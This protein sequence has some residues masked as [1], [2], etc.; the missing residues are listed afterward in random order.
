MARCKQ[1]A[2]VSY[3]DSVEDYKVSDWLKSEKQK[4]KKTHETGSTEEFFEMY[5]RR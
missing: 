2:S 1:L 5:Y 3:V 4:Q